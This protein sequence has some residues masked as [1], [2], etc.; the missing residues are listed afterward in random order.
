MD[1]GHPSFVPSTRPV[2]PAAAAAIGCGL[3]SLIPFLGFVFG[4]L[5]IVLSWYSRGKLSEGVHNGKHQASLGLLLG[6]LGILISM[7]WVI[8]FVVPESDLSGE[9][10]TTVRRDLVRNAAVLELRKKLYGTYPGTL[11]N[12]T[13]E[14]FDPVIV[15]PYLYEYYYEEV[16]GGYQLLSVGPDGT[17][18]TSDDIVF[19]G[20]LVSQ[21]LGIR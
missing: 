6:I 12:L 3:L 18:H 21:P 16:E 15:D 1:I 20:E 9:K 13:P 10:A 17:L 2:L 4:P 7:L 11:K 8:N 19:S 14:G 5:A